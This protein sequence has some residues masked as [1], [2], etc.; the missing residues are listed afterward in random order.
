M[1]MHRMTVPKQPK[2]YHIVHVDRLP[3]IIADQ[4]LWCDAKMVARDANGTTIGMSRIKQRRLN[5]LQ[6]ASYPGLYVGSCVP[7]YFCPRSIM[8]HT[9]Y[10]ANDPDL[11][12][13]DGQE[14]VIHLE[15]DLFTAIEWANANA[16]KWAF[17]LSN[18][19][20]R[21]FVDYN[22]VEQLNKINWKAIQ[23][24][25]WRGELKEG[26]QAEF[27]MEHSFPW[28]LIERIGVRS[29]Q[30]FQRVMQALHDISHRPRVEIIP[31]WYY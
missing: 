27:L 20:A 14:P 6:L 29:P 21:Y 4:F 1:D 25:D 26:K 31:V 15:S 9:I 17:T 19:G 18:A 23:A 12:Y 3:S 2:I 11:Q 8:L 30:I 5:E 16:R 13:R 7:F 28:Q 22:S 10:K 24:R